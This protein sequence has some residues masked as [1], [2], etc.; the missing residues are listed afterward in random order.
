ML[1]SF[2]KKNCN[3]LTPSN[4]GQE[5][6]ILCKFENPQIVASDADFLAPQGDLNRIQPLVGFV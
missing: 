6:W 1:Q 4:N 5:V 2:E 3:L